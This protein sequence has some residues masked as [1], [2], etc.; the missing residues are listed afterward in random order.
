MCYKLFISNEKTVSIIKRF[1]H[2]EEEK[3]FRKSEKYREKGEQPIVEGSK[4]KEIIRVWKLNVRNTPVAQLAC[5]HQNLNCPN[6]KK[7][8]VLVLCAVVIRNK[9]MGRLLLRLWWKYV[10]PDR[11]T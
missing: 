4:H 5:V 8:S 7:E 6:E 10:N 1:L 9:G 2:T 3:V 11:S